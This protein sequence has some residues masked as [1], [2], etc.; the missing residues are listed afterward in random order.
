MIQRKKLTKYAWLSIAAAV[1]TIGIK[2]SAYLLTGSVGLLSD[3]LESGVNLVA[4]FLALIVLTVAAQPPDREHAYGHDKAEYFASGVEGTLIVIAAFVIAISAI[5]SLLDPQPLERLGVGLTVS[6]VAALLNLIVARVLLRAG[7]QY[8]SVTL[9]ADAKHLMTD[10][11]TTVGVL[12]GVT[13]VAITGWQPLDPIIALVVATQI[14]LAGIKLVRGAVS[15][16][17]DTALPQ[18]E[19]LKIVNILEKYA[20]DGVQYHALRTRQ[21]GARRFMS[22]HIQVPGAWSVQNGHSLLEEFEEEIR[23]TLTPITVL[24]HLEPLE[25]PRSWEDIPISRDGGVG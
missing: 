2:L 25:D 24:T 10:V 18:E 11:W 14:V 4:A 9:E 21:S 16:L 23:D 12:A 7:K 5:D 17:M 6:V 22:V 20:V 15:G 1:A 8:R 13:A 3:A 19:I